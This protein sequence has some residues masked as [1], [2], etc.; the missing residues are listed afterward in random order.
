ME[1]GVHFSLH[2]TCHHQ[3][4][5]AKINLK[6]YYPPPYEREIWHYEKANADL[7]LRSIDQFHWDIRFAHIYVNQKVHLFNQ[8]I[9]NILCNFKPHETVTC[10]H[11]W[12]NSKIKGLMQKKNFARKCYFQ[13]SEDILLFRRF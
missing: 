3:I 5:F 1:S 13:N 2:S 9:K 6:I 10:D 11:P 12:I 7:I 4:A 8:T